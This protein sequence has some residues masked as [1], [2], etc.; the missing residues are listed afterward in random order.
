MVHLSVVGHL[1]C[2]QSLAIM[3]SAA[4]NIGVQVPTVSGLTFFWVDAQE[5]YHWIIWQFYL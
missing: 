2:F 5:Q 3:N 4:V 1:G